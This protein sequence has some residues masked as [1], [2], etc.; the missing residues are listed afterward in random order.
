MQANGQVVAQLTLRQFDEE[1]FVDSTSS[2]SVIEDEDDQTFHN[3][4]GKDIDNAKPHHSKGLRHRGEHKS[5]DSVPHHAL[6]KM[7]FP[8]FDGTDPKI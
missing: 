8:K 4:F 3:V 2:E 7:F 1:G 5:T 6:P